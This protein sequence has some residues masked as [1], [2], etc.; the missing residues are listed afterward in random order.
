MAQGQPHLA[1]GLKLPAKPSQ[2]C[3]VPRSPAGAPTFILQRLSPNQP[4][5]P[6]PNIPI[7]MPQAW[8]AQPGNSPSSVLGRSRPR[9]GTPAISLRWNSSL[10]S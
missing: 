4:Q 10:T 9:A 7:L 8:F 5:R 1:P 3:E 2:A 6:S